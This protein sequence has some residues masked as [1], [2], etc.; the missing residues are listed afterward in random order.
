MNERKEAQR[1]G[2][3]TDQGKHADLNTIKHR[4]NKKQFVFGVSK[5]NNDLVQMPHL[6]VLVV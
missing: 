1:G 4:S 3:M 5:V 6:L 2:G